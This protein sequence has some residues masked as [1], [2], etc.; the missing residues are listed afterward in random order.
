[1]ESPALETGTSPKTAEPSST[2]SAKGGL[3]PTRLARLHNTLL[4]HVDSGRLPGL[5]AV[6]SRRGA[7]HVDAIGTLAFDRTAP[8]QR[9]TLFRLASVTKPI[10]AVA[11]MILVEE[12][13]LRLDDPV[14]EFLPELA[15]RKVLR[16][17]DSELDDT[18]PAKRPITVRDLLT[19]R[20]GYGEVA[21]LSPMCPLQTALIEARLPLSTFKF[22]G[23]PDEFM[24]CLG[25][26]PLA[27]QPG[28]RWLYHMS[29]EILGVL[30]ARVSGTSLSAFMRKRIFDPLG[31][32][33]TGFTV[34]QA[35]LDRVATCYQTDFSSGEITVLE[36]ARN[37][38]LARP[39][40]FESG[41]GDQL[42][43]TA[44]DLLAFGRMMLNRGAYGTDRILSRLSVELMTTDQITAEQKAASP[45][46]EKFWDSRG[47]GLG[48]SIVTRRDEVASV[49]GRYGWDGAFSTSLYVDPHEDMVGV[50]MAQCRPGALRLPPVVLDFWTSAYQAIDD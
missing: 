33:D 21:F 23:T 14:D 24:Q 45:F 43:S 1:M 38:L 27:N 10:T 16:T 32:K 6:I 42:V 18:V 3:S 35:Q 40:V 4:R 22:A 39:C 47:W 26:L 50:L 34:P 11:A 41:A 19:F 29:A 5:V 28:E 49:P 36:E 44:D 12:C 15:N 8:M 30:I 31:M 2:Q 7:E 20:S 46:F 37:E 13:K 17:I 48:V 25:S 9:D